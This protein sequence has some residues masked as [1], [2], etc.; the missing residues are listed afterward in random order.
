MG[1]AKWVMGVAVLVG[2]GTVLPLQAEEPQQAKNIFLMIS[3]GMGF[4]GWEAAKFFQEKPLPYDN[5][6]FEFYGMTTYMKN[7]HDPQTDA[8][9]PSAGK[10]GAEEDWV[11]VG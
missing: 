9:I 4:N 10:D 8:L 2:W 3:D 5:D 6:Q 11:G 1:R 7:T